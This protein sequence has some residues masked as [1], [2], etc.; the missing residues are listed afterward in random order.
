MRA[1]C[2]WAPGD[3]DSNIRSDVDALKSSPYVKN[4]I[5]IVGYVLDVETGK[6]KEVKYGAFR[7]PQP[8]IYGSSH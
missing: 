2:A 6:L 8:V 4:E 3:S 7:I 5:P 1:G